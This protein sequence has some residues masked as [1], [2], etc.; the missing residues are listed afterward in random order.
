MKV[1]PNRYTSYWE[2]DQTMSPTIVRVDSREGD[3]F[4]VTMP[5]GIH[6]QVHLHTIGVI[7]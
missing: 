3:F 5:T 7:R 2:S 1:K 6:K 4:N